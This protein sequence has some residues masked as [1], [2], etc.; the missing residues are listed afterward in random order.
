MKYNEKEEIFF[1]N[2][3]SLYV[4]KEGELLKKELSKIESQDN[5]DHISFQYKNLKRKISIFKFRQFSYKAMPLVACLL[6]FAIYFNRNFVSDRDLRVKESPVKN[7]SIEFISSKLPAEYKLTDI[8]YDM[9]KTIYYIAS[10]T[11]N[12]II[13]TLEEAGGDFDKDIFKEAVINDT[14]VYGLVK[15]DFNVLIYE[16]DNLLYKLTSIY[17]YEDL[18]ELS[19]NLI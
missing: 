15:N 12:N 8:N 17:N 13:L 2:I 16:K 7:L 10:N 19:K 6:I 9:D 1:K 18:I 5:K 14:K 4:E 11:Q 3:A